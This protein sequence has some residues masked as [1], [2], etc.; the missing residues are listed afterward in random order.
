V[1][2]LPPPTLRLQAP[3]PFK[4]PLILR[5]IIRLPD[6]FAYFVFNKEEQLVKKKIIGTFSHENFFT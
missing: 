1:P 6:A 5:F 2:N 4:M 3:L